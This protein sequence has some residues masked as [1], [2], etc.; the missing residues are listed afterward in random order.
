MLEAHT[1]A[2]E[3]APFSRHVEMSID[4]VDA[5]HARTRQ[6]LSDTDGDL[7]L[8]APGVQQWASSGR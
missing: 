8:T 2:E 1:T 5:E 3:R 4:D 7:T 6:H